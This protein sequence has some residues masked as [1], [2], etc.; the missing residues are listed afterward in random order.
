MFDDDLD[1]F[2]EDAE[3]IVLRPGQEDA[4]PI[5]GLYG[6][7]L[8]SAEVLGGLGLSQNAQTLLC[9]TSDVQGLAMGTQLQVVGKTLYSGKVHAID[10]GAF[11]IVGLQ[12]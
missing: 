10:D 11:S 4:L 3:E 1:I 12:V 7:N 2:L 5:M 9:K 6:T 8:A